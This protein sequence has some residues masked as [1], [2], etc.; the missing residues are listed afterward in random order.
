MSLII[1]FLGVFI[2][3]RLEQ[4]LGLFDKILSEF[5]TDDKN[6]TSAGGTA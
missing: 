1:L 2:A 3:L 6:D 4:K 5:T